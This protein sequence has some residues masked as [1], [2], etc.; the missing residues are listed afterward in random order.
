VLAQEVARGVGA[1]GAE[2]DQRGHDGDG[3]LASH[4]STIAR[5]DRG[6]AQA[7]A[8]VAAVIVRAIGWRAHAAL[9]RSAGWA[10]VVAPLRES[11]YVEA[12]GQLA[13]VGRE[14]AM[15][16]PRAVLATALPATDTGTVHL[17]G[18]ALTPWRAQPLALDAAGAR[19]L[20]EASRGLGAAIEAVGRPDG[21]AAA[22]LGASPPS[23]TMALGIAAAAEPARRLARAC[24]ADDAAAALEPAL[25]LLGLGPGLT[26]SGDDYAGGAFF[27]RALLAAGGAADASGWRATAAA[28]LRVAATRTHAISAAL[29]ADHVEGDGHAAL[30][31]LARALARGEHEPAVAAARRLATLGHSSGWDI[32]AGFLGGLSGA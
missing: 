1:G 8:S 9:G 27:A 30:H 20:V 29:L 26:P 23:A 19:R 24:A 16:H 11:V 32:L 7:R 22:L 28:L 14:G 2:Q 12:A 15:L 4:R 10:R 21:L 18:S 13:W 31:E 5:P 3:G 6:V 17:D 25:G